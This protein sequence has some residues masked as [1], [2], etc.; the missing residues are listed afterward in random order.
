M[1]DDVLDNDLG[2]F[3]V[4]SG[5]LTGEECSRA[6]ETLVR[7]A[8]ELQDELLAQVEHMEQFGACS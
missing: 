4:S 3:S 5:S 1:A 8:N 2:L 7:V 6:F